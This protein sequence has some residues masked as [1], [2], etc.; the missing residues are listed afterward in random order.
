[1]ALRK[2]GKYYYGD[3][4]KDLIIELERYADLNKYPIDETEAT[5]CSCCDGNIFMLFSDDEESAAMVQCIKC[6][7]KQYIRDSQRYLNNK[8]DN[9]T[10]ICGAEQFE[11]A[12]GVSFY[13]DTKDVRWV[14]VGGYCSKCG[15]VGNYVDWNER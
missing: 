13:T 11:I 7:N 2:K 3:N 9:Y 6:E 1:M 5:T 12:I 4:I 10:C 8:L 15:L 14:Y